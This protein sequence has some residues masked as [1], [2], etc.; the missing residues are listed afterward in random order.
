MF[1]ERQITKIKKSPTEPTV[2]IQHTP[3]HIP[4]HPNIR[5]DPLPSVYKQICRD[6][7]S[8]SSLADPMQTI[9]F[10]SSHLGSLSTYQP[11]HSINELIW[12]KKAP[13]GPHQHNTALSE[14]QRKACS[15]SSRVWDSDIQWTLL[16]S[17]CWTPRSEGKGIRGKISSKF[18]R[19]MMLSELFLKLHVTDEFPHLAK[20]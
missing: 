14:S 2:V 12:Y 13:M 8:T 11:H 17:C 4:D 10:S 15:L 9:Y 20:L 1:P 6:L 16:S 7:W 19:Q 5:N 18:A 3:I